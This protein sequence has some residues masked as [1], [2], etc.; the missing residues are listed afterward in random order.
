[1][2]NSIHLYH[3]LRIPFMGFYC[4]TKGALMSRMEAAGKF[5]SQRSL[6]F[7]RCELLE[8]TIA[9]AGKTEKAIAFNDVYFNAPAGTIGHFSIEGDKHPY[10]EVWG[11]GLIIATPAGSTAY[12]YNAGGSIIP[13]NKEVLTVTENNSGRRGSDVVNADQEIRVKFLRPGAVTHV[14]SREFKNATDVSVQ[15]ARRHVFLTF[16]K[17]EEFEIRR[18]RQS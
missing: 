10:K 6:E 13:L 4:G 1:L 5:P 2:L 7:I 14:D 17:G 12:N 9:G 8:A 16:Q 15:P 3:K 11:D 18:Y